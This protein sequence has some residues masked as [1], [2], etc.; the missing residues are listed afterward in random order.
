MKQQWECNHLITC[1]FASRLF[2]NTNTKATVK[3][4]A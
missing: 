3:W 2:I 1:C 4:L